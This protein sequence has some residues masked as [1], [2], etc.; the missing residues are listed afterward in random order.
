MPLRLWRMDAPLCV[1]RLEPRTLSR[2]RSGELF[3]LTG[4]F[5]ARLAILAGPVERRAALWLSWI[6]ER[7]ISGESAISHNA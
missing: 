2:S 3:L 7:G 5:S 4:F 6:N 1:Q